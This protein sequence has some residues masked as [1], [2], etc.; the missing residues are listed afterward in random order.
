[1]NI[2]KLIAPLALAAGVGIAALTGVAN[3]STPGCVDGVYAG[4]C[5]TQT[6]AEATGLSLDVFQQHAT[7]N[8]KIIGYA[9]S[10][11]D[12]A[13]DFY[14][15]AFKGGPAKIF[16]YAPNG[17]ASGLCVSE[18]SQG[19]GLVLRKCTGS[20]WQQFTAHR[21]TTPSAA[22]SFTWSNGA[23]GD[24]IATAGARSQVVGV[25]PPSGTTSATVP[26]QDRFVF[27]T[28]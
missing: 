14:I 20:L 6:N 22:D 4:Y 26:P 15:F 11:N 1:M 9:N 13:T 21:I 18:P 28:N 27:V 5:G 10:D 23:S 2:R 12:R 8:N 16:E 7:V 17:V 19:A 3:A 25:L 24:I